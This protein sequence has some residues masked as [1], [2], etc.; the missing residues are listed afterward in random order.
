[1]EGLEVVHLRRAQRREAAI[2]LTNG[3]LEDPAWVAIGPPDEPARR[4]LLRRFFRVAVTF[5]AGRNFPSPLA[6]VLEAPLFLLAGGRTPQRATQVGAAMAR[7]HPRGP[8]LYLWFLAVDPAHQRSGV[9]RALMQRVLQDA[10]EADVPVYLETA[11]SS[12]VAYYRSFGFDVTGEAPL[13][14]RGRMWFM[15]RD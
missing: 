4:R 1:M 11:S 9:G 15:W 14:G 3:F 13:P 8:H 6:S 5:G 2:V 7:A 12:N 10:A